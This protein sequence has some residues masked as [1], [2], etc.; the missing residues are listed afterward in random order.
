MQIL[1]PMSDIVFKAIFGKEDKTSKELLIALLNDILA[2]ENPEPITDISHLNP[3][4]YKDFAEDK[5]SILDIKAKTN[6]GEIINIEVQVK[7]EDNYRKR[8]LYYWS[9]TYAETISAGQTY[10]SLQKT[11]I[12]NILGY[13]EIKESQ[14]LHTVFKILEKTDHFE[15]L[16]D[17]QIHYL[18]LPKLPKRKVEELNELEL[19]LD[20]LKEAGN[21]KRLKQLKE[22]SAVMSSLVNKLQ[23]VSADEIMREKY[24]AREKARL[25]YKSAMK[26]AENRGMERGIEKGMEQGI[27]KGRQEG[28]QEGK[29][30]GRQEMARNM[31]LGGESIE[32]II[33]YTGLGKEEI[34]KLKKE[35][36]S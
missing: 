30:E 6:S 31:L 1:D 5:L 25:D 8:S 23:E 16:D 34:N 24:N 3:F 36:E 17:L 19:W 32:R 9:K 27:E 10:E 14:K 4:N 29:Q 22:R 26:Y 7:R 13:N 18:E 35:V 15:L 12:I 20:F 21:G 33:K 28:K 2:N 11:I